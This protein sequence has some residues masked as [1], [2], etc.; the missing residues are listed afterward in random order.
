MLLNPRDLLQCQHDLE[1][2]LHLLKF[3]MPWPDLELSN[4]ILLLVMQIFA[5]CFYSVKIEVLFSKIKDFLRFIE[6]Q[7]SQNK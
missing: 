2:N 5:S 1:I 7:T 3:E 6:T 4:L